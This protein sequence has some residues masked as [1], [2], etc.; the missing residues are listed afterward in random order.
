M[1]RR[2]QSATGARVPRTLILFV[3]VSLV[4]SANPNAPSIAA[5]YATSPQKLAALDESVRE[6]EERAST[7]VRNELAAVTQ[8]AERA[9]LATAESAADLCRQKVCNGH[10]AP[11][12]PPLG[13]RY[14]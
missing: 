8:A 10:G 2:A 12:G 3:I 6:H 7:A 11:H 4:S 14:S 13:D 5:M 1:R 9:L